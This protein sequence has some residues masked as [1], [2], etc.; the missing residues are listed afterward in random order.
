[1]LQDVIDALRR[2]SP[3]ALALARAETVALP[4]SADA[5]HLLGIAQREAGDADGARA[6]F[7]RAIELAPEESLYH[8][9]LAVLAHAQDDLDSADCASAQALALDPN[10]LGAYLLR[11]QIAI[12]RGDAV[13]A[14]RQLQLA[15]RVDPEHPSLQFA[16]G[17]IAMAKNEGERA[18][19]LLNAAAAAMPNDV[20]VLI[21]LAL[22]YQRYGHAAFAEQALRKA[23]TLQPHS[24]AL[25]RSLISSLLN[26]GRIDD[27]LREV[28]DYRREHPE[29]PAGH[30]LEA[31]LHWRAGDATAALNAYRAVLDRAP[32][33]LRALMGAQRALEA[34]GDRELSRA[35]WEGVLQ[36]DPESD[37]TWASRLT[38]SA[39]E[40]DARDV[41]RRWLAAMPESA[42]ARLNQARQD[43]TDGREAEAEA[44][45]DAVLARVPMQF[46]AV[47]GKAAL[48]LRRDPAA[49]IARLEPVIAN[50]PPSQSK[51][52]LT[53][54]G[55]ARDTL[56]ETAA[57]VAD[58]LQA[59]AGLGA[60]PPASPL[61]D[62]TLRAL[63]AALPAAA[64]QG[65][66][67]VAMLWGPPGSGSER[68]AATLRFTPGRPLMLATPELLPR[69]LDLSAPQIARAL[70]PD[71][72]PALAERVADEYARHVGSRQQQGNAGV[73]D[74][75][76]R[77]DARAAPLLQEAV[78]GT[79][80]LAVLRDP[81][82]ML[83]NWLAFGAPAGPVFVDPI[84]NAA[85]LANQL[86]HLL[87]ARD[88]LQLPTLIV[89]M[90]RFDAEPQTALEEIVAFADLSATP[91][92]QPALN[93]RSGPGRMP[94]LLPAGR[95]R[96]YR[97]ELGE[98]FDL[99]A[100]LAERLGYPRD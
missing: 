10:Q 1:M 93:R 64:A 68:L 3:D 12:A 51:P 43:E 4:D 23:R 37:P 66:P 57:A 85:W 62:E 11:I 16:A 31:G 54:R 78:P 40:D 83:L 69:A 79:R 17:Q 28:A 21:T 7:D 45:Y 89:D 71:E 42:A 22:A 29:D 60:L 9:S 36:R 53:W 38:T 58:W 63:R 32:R 92:P 59:H 6:S 56:N 76:A 25:H 84:E 47:L 88:E 15:E 8:F 70:N 87:F 74:W 72:L 61:P 46:D 49:G 55:Q 98:A 39:D 73:F 99:L 100:P 75:L 30:S 48:E 90:D 82:D 65:A 14:E 34:I 86:K 18:I 44:G 27:A 2:H 26:Q 24:A 33:D 13:E 97:G 50:A 95:W 91:D 77:W 5:H 52:A 81:R 96:A 19:G 80:L 67:T 94:S 41:L 20:Q 35:V